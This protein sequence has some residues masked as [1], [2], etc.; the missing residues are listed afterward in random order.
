M[1]SFLGMALTVLILLGAAGCG[2]KGADQAKQ[3]FVDGIISILEDNQSHPEIMEEGQKAFIAYYQSGFGDLEKAAAAAE[4]FE[5]SNEKDAGTLRE[6]GELEKPDDRASAIAA[7]LE[8][9]IRTMDEGNSR[10]AEELRRAAGQ[11]QEQRAGINEAG[12]AIMERHYL[13]GLDAIISALD[14]LS[15]Y[16]RDHGLQGEKRLQE[17]LDKFRQERRETEMS[18]KYM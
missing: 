12:K 5:K 3:A 1:S 7:G 2:G 6:L 18:L 16:V 14:G 10:Y 11:S 4:S 8:E 17:M 13:P 15:G 9:G